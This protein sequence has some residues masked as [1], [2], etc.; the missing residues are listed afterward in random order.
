MVFG[1]SGR[2]PF[3]QSCPELHRLSGF[4]DTKTGSG[5]SNAK[6]G[7]QRSIPGHKGSFVS[8]WID[9]MDL[10]NIDL[11]RDKISRLEQYLHNIMYIPGVGQDA[12]RRRTFAS[13]DPEQGK[14]R[15][16]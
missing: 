16:V 1:P 4:D 7:F 2:Y 5:L 6:V 14:S 8:R 9:L 11:G 13:T 3:G 12:R 10:D 15:Q